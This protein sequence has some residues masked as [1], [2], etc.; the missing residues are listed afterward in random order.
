[1]KHPPECTCCGACVAACP[2]EQAGGH[3]LVTFLAN[4]EARDY[5]AWLCTSCRRCQEVCPEGVDIYGL[6]MAQRRREPPP[7]G[8]AEAMRSLRACGL[9]LQ[10]S[11]KELDEMRAA[12]GLEPVKLPPPDLARKLLG[13]DS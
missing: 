3:A 5:S 12:W 11:Q 1:M 10:I 6:I 9:T 2:V 8:Y 4:P 13:D 7:A